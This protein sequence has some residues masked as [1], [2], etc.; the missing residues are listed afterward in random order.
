MAVG[1]GETQLAQP[2]KT[3]KLKTGCSTVVPPVVN[4][5]TL[6][7]PAATAV[8]KISQ[9]SVPDFCDHWTVSPA[10]IV[11]LVRVK[12]AGVWSLFG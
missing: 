4:I 6:Q 5:V 8:V 2:L 12:L 7:L 3:V 9:R 10:A 11:L 1:Q